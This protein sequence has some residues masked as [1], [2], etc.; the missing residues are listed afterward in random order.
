[1]KNILPILF[2]LLL[3]SYGIFDIAY[4]F[5]ISEKGNTIEAQIIQNNNAC[6][7]K[8]KSI[9][10]LYHNLEK[11]VKIFGNKCRENE[12]PIGTFLKLKTNSKG[13]RFVLPAKNYFTILIVMSLIY[14]TLLIF[15][16]LQIKKYL[17][18]KKGNL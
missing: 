1:M 12:F 5:Y 6:R 11:E 9:V 17:S 2:C 8:N 18:T 7:Y 14:S 4:D 3:F 10:V 13:N 16:I 15:F